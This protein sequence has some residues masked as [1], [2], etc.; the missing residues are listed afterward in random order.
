MSEVKKRN[1]TRGNKEGSV[2]K[3]SGK[4]KRPWAARIT[5]GW[6]KEGKQQLRYIGYFK[7]KTEAKKALN[8]YLVNP[9]SLEKI[10]T[11]E[12]FE[13]WQQT[14]KFSEEVIKNYKR[15]VENS[16]LSK[17]VFKDV[18]LMQL[19]EALRALSPSMQKRF[20]SAWKNLYIY[21][22]KHDIVD[23]NLAEL[24]DLDKY[25]AKEKDVI[26]AEDIKKILAMENVIPKLLLFTGTRINELLSIKSKNVDIKN[27]IMVLGSK[28]AAGRDRRVPISKEIM[29]IIESLLSKGTD[30]LIT[31]DKG[32]KVNYNSFLTNFWNKNDVLK[33]YVI[34]QT[35]HS[36]VSRSVKL[37]LDR[38][39]LQ[40]II[41][42]ANKDTTDIYTHILD[43]DL[44][45]WIDN[46][47]Y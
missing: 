42:H 18:K 9:Y 5:V 29:P 19:E 38:G 43:E 3:L 36:F 20:R 33:K 39:T 13:K 1:R 10:T 14:S 37:K 6:S 12:L 4:R 45:I 40:K 46:F 2:I 24:M 27:R 28:T 21:G 23:K 16:G 17:T 31:D 26:S 30:Y 11:I 7:T 15:V 25:K 41:G 8:N 47:N 34:H 32:K 35:R 22:L 44:V